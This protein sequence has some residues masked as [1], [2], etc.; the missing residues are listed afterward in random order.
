MII[1][2]IKD[3][4]IEMQIVGEKNYNNIEKVGKIC[5][6]DIRIGDLNHFF[7]I[8]GDRISKLIII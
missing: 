3:F 2:K 8:N 4:I 7:I 1:I 5:I 6:K